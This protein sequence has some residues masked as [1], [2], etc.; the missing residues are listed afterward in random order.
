MRE[1]LWKIPYERPDPPEALLRAG[2]PP[3]LAEILK[4]R[5]MTGAEEA[6]RFFRGG[7]E[8]LHEP[9]LLQDM[10]RAVARLRRAIADGETVAVYGDYDVDGITSTCQ[11]G[12]AHV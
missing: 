8:Q 1:K 11:I 7:A 6:E 12:R 9:L 2:C 5:G 10:D 3:L 4:L